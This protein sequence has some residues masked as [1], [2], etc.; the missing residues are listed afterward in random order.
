MAQSLPMVHG[1]QRTRWGLTAHCPG[2]PCCREGS[3]VC[4]G[5]DFTPVCEGQLWVCWESVESSRTR[6]AWR[7]HY[8]AHVGCCGL[9]GGHLPEP[10]NPKHWCVAC[11]G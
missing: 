5:F 2:A 8:P 11:T 10:V 4:L 3:A 6:G 7:C 9:L 1:E